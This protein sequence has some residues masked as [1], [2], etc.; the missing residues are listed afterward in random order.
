M[1]LF[2]A[3]PLGAILTYVVSLLIGSQGS[4]GGPLA[5]FRTEL[6]DYTL[7]WSWPLFLAATGLAW[8]IMMMQR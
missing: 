2:K 6:Y 4:T 7:W 5:I 3:A 8:G 1:E